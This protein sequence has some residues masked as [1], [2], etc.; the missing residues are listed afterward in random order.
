MKYI[1]RSV[2]HIC[3]PK[4][5]SLE[6]CLVELYRLYIGLCE[7][8]GKD[9][10]DFYFK[11]KSQTLGFYKIPV[12]INSLNKIL[13]DLCR[14]VGIKKKTAYCLRVTCASRLLQSGV[15]EKLVMYIMHCLSMK[16][17]AKIKVNMVLTF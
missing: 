3:H 15:D 2:T 4:G 1:P 7:T 16:R 14:A 8:F 6:Q 13:P 12:G 10:S 9:I 17:P 11:P 5:Q